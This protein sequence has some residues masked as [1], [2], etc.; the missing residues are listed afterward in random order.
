MMLYW[1]RVGTLSRMTSPEFDYGE[2]PLDPIEPVPGLPNNPED[3]ISE[4]SRER[5]RQDLD[6]LAAN[7]R[8]V[9]MRM[10]SRC[11][12]ACSEGSDED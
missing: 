2:N 6:A 1:S 7:R 3:L 9:A 4:E 12:G 11:A 8:R 10:G 5:L